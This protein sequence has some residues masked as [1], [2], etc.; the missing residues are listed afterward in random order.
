MAQRTLPHDL[1]RTQQEWDR[2]YR[3]LAQRPGRR[4]V[5][6]RRLLRL[7][8]RLYFHPALA[9]PGARVEL[10]RLAREPDEA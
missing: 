5:L 3:A 4:A 10:E 7:S 8:T 6:R 2:T 1:V 9:R